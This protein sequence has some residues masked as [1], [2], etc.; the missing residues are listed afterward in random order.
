MNV[1][2]SAAARRRFVVA[3][4]VAI[5]A[6]GGLTMAVRTY[7]PFLTDATELREFV[8]GFGV[9]APLVFVAIQALQVVVA[10]IP[11]QVT[12][13]VSGYLFG[14]VLGTVYSMVG[15]TIGSTVAFWLSRRYG[16]SFVESVVSD[17]VMETFDAFVAD[18]GLV[19][20]FVVFLVPG[21]PDDAICFLA[22]LT[23][24]DLWKLVVVAFVGR[25]PAYALVNV[26]GASLADENV[27]LGMLLLVGLAVA[28]IWGLLN[29]ERVLSLVGVR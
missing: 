28:S 20:L 19:G 2:E 14:A 3:V 24:V 4:L 22:G 9:V 17:D 25:T 16:R 8:A 23:D 1:F 27:V 18:A 13:L 10:P 12:G 29:R 11:G 6:F 7:A 26:S 5:A 15:L 21:P